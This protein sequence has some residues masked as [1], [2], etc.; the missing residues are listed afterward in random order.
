MGLPSEVLLAGGKI[1]NEHLHA[2]RS[3]QCKTF[4]FFSSMIPLKYSKLLVKC[5]VFDF[6]FFVGKTIK[7]N[8]FHGIRQYP[9]VFVLSYHFI[10]GLGFLHQQA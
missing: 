6:H 4:L 2:E 3:S 10:H 1:P 9:G 8:I 5:L 7:S